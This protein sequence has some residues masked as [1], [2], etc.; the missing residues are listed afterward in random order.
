MGFEDYD[1]ACSE[2]CGDDEWRERPDPIKTCWG[3]CRRW[4]LPEEFQARNGNRWWCQGQRDVGRLCLSIMLSSLDQKSGE[5][6]FQPCWDDSHIRGQPWHYRDAGQGP[7]E[8]RSAGFLSSERTVR[9]NDGI[10]Y[11][12]IEYIGIGIGIGMVKSPFSCRSES[13][14][15]WTHIVRTHSFDVVA[16]LTGPPGRSI[17]T[18]IRQYRLRCC[19]YWTVLS[20]TVS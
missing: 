7:R 9:R 15:T 20:L 5:Q 10:E 8:V 11:I 4:A 13:M 2:I 16:K 14:D 18:P 12:G 3:R 19:A 17:G 6:T 1:E